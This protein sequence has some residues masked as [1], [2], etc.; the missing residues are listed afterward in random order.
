MP[1]DKSMKIKTQK[2]SIDFTY[3]STIKK[4]KKGAEHKTCTIQGTK[5]NYNVIL[6]DISLLTTYNTK[7]TKNSS[8]KQKIKPWKNQNITTYITIKVVQNIIIY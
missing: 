4:K 5:T 8:Q 2:Y 7:S 3:Q 1:N 6:V